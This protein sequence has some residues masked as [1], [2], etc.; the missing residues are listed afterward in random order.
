MR[1]ASAVQALA[2]FFAVGI[3]FVLFC[4]VGLLAAGPLGFSVILGGFGFFNVGSAD[5]R[6]GAG[7]TGAWRA[8]WASAACRASAAVG[9]WAAETGAS[10]VLALAVWGPVAV[11]ARWAG[12]VLAL[13]AVWR[14]GTVARRS[15]S[16]RTRWTGAV[17]ARRSCSVR[18]WGPCAVWAR[19]V[20]IWGPAAAVRAR[21]STFPWGASV[22]RRS[23]F[24]WRALAFRARPAFG[25]CAFRAGGRGSRSIYRRFGFGYCRL[26][27]FRFFHRNSRRSSVRYFSYARLAAFAFRAWPAR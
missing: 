15:C 26:G 13:A 17:R 19:A 11:W 22:L 4:L 9:A 16:I 7:C 24:P 23:S 6:T 2:V 18:A 12:A 27:G 14:T 8:A 3:F 21:G 1:S 5:R 25:A 20:F 10:A